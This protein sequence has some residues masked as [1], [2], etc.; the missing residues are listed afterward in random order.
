MIIIFLVRFVCGIYFYIEE[1]GFILEW[2]IYSANS[3]NVEM[4]MLFDWISLIFVSVVILISS[5]VM[6]YRVYYMH[7]DL[8]INR[9]YLLVFIFIISI[10][11]MIIRPNLVRILLGWD[12]LGLVSYCLVIYYQNQSSFNSGIITVLSN[13]VGDVGLLMS[14]GLL[15]SRGRW[16]IYLLNEYDLL[17]IFMVFLAAITKSAQIPFSYWLPQ[18]IAAPT[19]VSSLV[20]SSTLVTAGVYLIIRFNFYICRSGINYILMILSILTRLIAGVIA[21]FEYDLKKIIALSTLRQLGLIIVTLGIGLVDIAFYHLVIHALFKS[22]LFLCSG[23]IIHQI[24]NNQDIRFYGGLN[25]FIPLVMIRFLIARLALCGAP[26]LAGFYS[27]D[28]L[29][30]SFNLNKINL[31]M[32]VI[33]ILSL[34]ITVRYTFRLFY[35]VF[36][37][38]VIFYFGWFKFPNEWL[39]NIS[40]WILVVLRIVSGS[41]F[42]WLF[43]FDIYEPYIDVL[44]KL[45]TTM[46]CILGIIGGFIFCLFPLFK[47]YVLVCFVSSIWITLFFYSYIYKPVFMCR[48]VSNEFDKTWVEFNTKYLFIYLFEKF[49]ILFLYS[50]KIYIFRCLILIFFLIIIII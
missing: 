40:I 17:I 20:H 13:R 4:F 33:I 25:E 5:I 7:G 31:L 9:F 48:C 2:L 14:I 49:K 50:Y 41:V 46:A 42:N 37:S 32:S 10:V 15:F 22:L 34:V 47:F 35:Y 27:K 3:I 1:S 18:A 30:E 43:F 8:F 23:I 26:F 39:I 11:L 44:P 6:F 38:E 45:F 21:N 36:F 19:P 28:L 12:G 16:N 29:V 24:L